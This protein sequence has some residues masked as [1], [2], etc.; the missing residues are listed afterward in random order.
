VF[1]S[2]DGG[3]FFAAAMNG[4]PLGTVITDLEVDDSPHFI[5]A[6]TYGRGAW[7]A[8]LAAADVIFED[9]FESGNTSAWSAP[10]N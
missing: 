4:L 7:Q 5:T 6:G 3:L 10:K 1:E 8:E 9:G 2:L